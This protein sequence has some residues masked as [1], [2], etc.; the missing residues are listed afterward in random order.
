MPSRHGSPHP[1]EEG[2]GKEREQQDGADGAANMGGKANVDGEG[3]P[4]TSSSAWPLVW[5]PTGDESAVSLDREAS[6]DDEYHALYRTLA[7]IPLSIFDL[8]C[9]LY[10]HHFNRVYP[11]LH[12][13]TCNPKSTLGQLLLISLGIGTVYAP[14]TG[15]LQLGRVLI[16]VA[17]RGMEHLINRDNRLARSL[18]VAQ[19]TLIWGIVR[20]IGLAQTVELAKVFAASTS[21][22]SAACA[23]ST[24]G[25]STSRK[26][27]RLWRSGRCSL[28]TR[29]GGG[30]RWF[31]FGE[32]TTLLHLPPVIPW[33]D[34]KMPLPCSDDLWNAPTAEA[35]LELKANAPEPA[36]IPAVAKER[37]RF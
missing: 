5:N 18:P 13:P 23:S 35:W 28:P 21:P 25:N 16:E 27:R 26:A 4:S 19:G 8:L 6:L 32:V 22:C 37:E 34:I 9:G 1:E 12:A 17:R 2:K 33:S 31:A 36:S 20:W 30:P 11:M 3:R 7:R 14:V 29:R 24:T 15:A 10:F